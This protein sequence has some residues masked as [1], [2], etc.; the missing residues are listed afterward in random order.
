MT[1]KEFW[2]ELGM[3]PLN[4]EELITPAIPTIP[5]VKKPTPTTSIPATH[6]PVHTQPKAPAKPT[7]K[8]VSKPKAKKDNTLAIKAFAVVMAICLLIASICL[9][10]HMNNKLDEALIKANEII[11]SAS[12]ESDTIIS[13][14]EESAEEK[15]ADA[16]AEAKNILEEKQ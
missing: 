13:A 15:I 5:Q 14:A 11:S 3:E 6:T 16:N 8:P 1:D 10:V 9:M 4:L 12:L 7:S 2:K